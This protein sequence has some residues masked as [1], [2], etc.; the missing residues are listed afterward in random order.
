[1][2]NFHKQEIQ[3]QNERDNLEKELNALATQDKQG[4]FMVR[5]DKGDGITVDSID[6]ADITEDFE[7]KIARLNVLE[8]QYK[9]VLKALEVLKQGTYGAC[10]VCKEYISKDRLRVNPSATTCV[11]HAE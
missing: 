6:N 9:Q 3:L 4:D 8:K 10:E 11:E 7:E 1:M 2:I 5:P